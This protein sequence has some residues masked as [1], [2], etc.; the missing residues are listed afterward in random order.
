MTCL[1]VRLSFAIIG[2]YDTISTILV[3]GLDFSVLTLRTTFHNRQ[4]FARVC[5]WHRGLEDIG[6]IEGGNLSCSK[7]HIVVM[8]AIGIKKLL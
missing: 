2:L 7:G 6:G 4:H 5:W 3:F 1:D 8:S